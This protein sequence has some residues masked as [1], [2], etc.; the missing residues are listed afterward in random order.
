MDK[1]NA[2]SRLFYADFLRAIA[3][4]CVILIHNSSDQVEQYGEIPMSNWWAAAFFNGIS[5][6]CIPLFV[7]LSGAFLLKPGKEVSMKELFGKRLAKLFIPL[8]IW[9]VIYVV[10]N[11]YTGQV[12]GDE[13]DTIKKFSLPDTLYGFYKGPLMYH[14]WYLYMLIGIYLLY[15]F[16][17]IF[18]TGAGEKYLRYFLI[19][20]LVV[21]CGLGIIEKINDSPVG[22]ELNGFTGYLGYF[23]LGYYLNTFSFSR[24]RLRLSYLL[25]IFG[26]ALSVLSPYLLQRLHVENVSE[27][28]ESDFTP[29]LILSVTGLFLLA[30]NSF[31]T[32]NPNGI[33]GKMISAVSKE[34]FGIYLVHV[35]VL[36]L[37]FTEERPYHDFLENLSP[38]AG[39]PLKALAVLLCAYLISWLIRQVPI[40]RKITGG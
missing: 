7:M 32:I 19:I 11:Y 24:K 40:L 10:Y 8:L 27:F 1:L 37:L 4:A 2:P 13:E 9:S 12:Q 28:T 6:F 30:K 14:L 22:I 25:C 5:R 23:L 31:H 29:D 18:I 36:D 16:L 15:P 17:N 20:W 3:I 35:L 38:W 34:S 33:F 26:F 39:I 21:N